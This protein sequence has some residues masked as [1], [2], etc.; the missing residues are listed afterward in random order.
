MRKSSKT[1]RKRNKPAK[2][3]KEANNNFLICEEVI[4]PK[5]KKT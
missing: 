4:H 2:G 1:E 3:V 5:V